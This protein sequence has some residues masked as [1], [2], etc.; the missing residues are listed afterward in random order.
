MN[1]DDYFKNLRKQQEQID[2]IFNPPSL[3]SY[4]EQQ[5]IMNK[6]KPMLK[7][8]NEEKLIFG[9][10]YKEPWFIGLKNQ[11]RL[12]KFSQVPTNMGIGTYNDKLIKSFKTQMKFHNAI[13]G[14][15]YDLGLNK[16]ISRKLTTALSSVDLMPLFKDIT[17]NDL[18]EI[19]DL[20]IKDLNEEVVNSQ[21]SHEIVKDDSSDIHSTLTVSKPKLI[22]DMTVDEFNELIQKAQVASSNVEQPKNRIKVFLIFI[23][24]AFANEAGNQ[25]INIIM[26]LIFSFSILIVTG[27]HDYEVSKVAQ[28]VINENQSVSTVRKVFIKN[29]DKLQEKPIG[30]LGFLRVSTELRV[31][32]S[33]NSRLVTKEII[34]KNTVVTPVAIK[35]N[36]IEVEVE[37]DSEFYIGWVQKSKIV[38]F[39]LDK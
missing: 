19:K 21:K 11:N 33:K 23:A 5:K 10:I 2:K 3:K 38:Y 14:S 25:I 30:K 34:N 39:K 20:S 35:G 16:S 4:R 22:S 12:L 32:P 24:G 15:I 36:W 37:T 29:K 27:N 13:K 31:Q 17:I 9:N 1:V 18:E 28:S 7:S 8:A 26:Q 6:Y